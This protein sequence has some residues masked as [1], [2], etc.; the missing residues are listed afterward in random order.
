[1]VCEPTFDLQQMHQYALEGTTLRTELACTA[2]DEQGC[3]LD[4][5]IGLAFD[6]LGVQVLDLR[7]VSDEASGTQHLFG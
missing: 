7:I 1:M 3:V 2:L 4:G 5:L 6:T